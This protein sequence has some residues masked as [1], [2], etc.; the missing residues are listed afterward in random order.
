[1]S[2]AGEIWKGLSEEERKE[3]DDMHDEDVK[4]YER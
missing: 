4:R 2:K 1:M 3:Y